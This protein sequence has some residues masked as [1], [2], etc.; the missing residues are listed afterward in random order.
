MSTI[1]FYRAGFRGYFY[2]LHDY[3]QHF[4]VFA[5]T[6]YYFYSKMNTV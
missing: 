5:M 6:L 1:D 3:F 4:A 2:K